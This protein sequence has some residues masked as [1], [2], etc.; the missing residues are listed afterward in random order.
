MASNL[1]GLCVDALEPVGFVLVAILALG[2]LASR[3]NDAGV[4]WLP[5]ALALTAMTRLNQALLFWTEFETLRDDDVVK[6]VVLVPAALGD[7]VM[8]WRN[9]FRPGRSDWTAV[10]AATLTGLL[11]A[12]L[13]LSRSRLAPEVLRPFRA[14][15]A[16]ASSSLR[17]GFAARYLWVVIWGGAHQRRWST[18]AALIAAALAGVGLFAEELC[19]LG[20]KGAFGFHSASGFPKPS[21]PT[22]RSSSCSSP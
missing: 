15:L 13:L 3:A 22:L 20:V 12:S 18:L 19:A 6:N 4:L 14:S 17:L 5:A 11:M 1:Q 2:L 9:W 7:W 8:A 21:S 10:A 16:L